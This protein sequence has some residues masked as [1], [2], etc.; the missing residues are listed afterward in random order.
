MAEVDIY[1]SKFWIW[2]R[3][4]YCRQLYSSSFYVF[5]NYSD[6]QFVLFFANYVTFFLLSKNIVL[7]SYLLW[8]ELKSNVVVCENSSYIHTIHSFCSSSYCDGDFEIWSENL[9]SRC[10]D[11]NLHLEQTRKIQYFYFVVCICFPESTR[12]FS[13]VPILKLTNKNLYNCLIYF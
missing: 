5:K 2:Y 8:S 10:D 12:Y 6:I 11:L 9:K 1:L 4:L 3:F 7:K 13:S